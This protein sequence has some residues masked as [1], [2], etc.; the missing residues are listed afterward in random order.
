MAVSEGAANVRS[1]I[2]IENTG[3]IRTTSET[4]NATGIFSFTRADESPIA[5]VNTGDITATTE[6][7]AASFGIS[8]STAG[9][10]SPVSIAKAVR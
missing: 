8:A 2:G 9:D 6:G 1:P 3:D 10:G 4:G 5:V 7:F